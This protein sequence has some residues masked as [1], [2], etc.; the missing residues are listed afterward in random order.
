M[1]L[2]ESRLSSPDELLGVWDVAPWAA[3]GAVTGKIPP[4]ASGC[5]PAQHPHSK[6][7]GTASTTVSLSWDC[8]GSA[9]GDFK[10]ITRFGV[11]THLGSLQEPCSPREPC[12]TTSTKMRIGLLTPTLGPIPSSVGHG[13]I[14]QSIPTF[15][16]S[17]PELFPQPWHSSSCW[18]LSTGSRACLS[19]VYKN[20]GNWCFKDLSVI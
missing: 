14:Q 3:H 13:L 1:S 12:T 4:M 16:H 20:E 7:K 10:L 17:L 9:P 6:D 18:K 11:H 8:S 15:Q 19:R 5:L 2:F